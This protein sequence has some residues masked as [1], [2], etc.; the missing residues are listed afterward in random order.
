MAADQSFREPTAIVTHPTAVFKLAASLLLSDQERNRHVC[1]VRAVRVSKV[2]GGF[3]SG[4]CHTMPPWKPS[5][6]S[7]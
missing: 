6:L 4:H 2:K 1:R 3:M 7:S 5:G